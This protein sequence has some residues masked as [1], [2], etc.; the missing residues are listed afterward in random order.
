MSLCIYV[1]EKYKFHFFTNIGQCDTERYK[2]FRLTTGCSGKISFFFIIHSNPSHAYISSLQKI[3]KAVNLMPV[4]SHFYWLVNL[5]NFCTTNSSPVVGIYK[6]KE[7]KR[8]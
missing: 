2:I 5:A 7:E 6:R 3:F 4:Y 1:S 8:T